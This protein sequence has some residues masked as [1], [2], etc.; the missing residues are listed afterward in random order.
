[1]DPLIPCSQLVGI[2]CLFVFD[3]FKALILTVYCIHVLKS[4]F[5]HAIDL[6]HSDPAKLQETAEG[7]Q[8]LSTNGLKKRQMETKVRNIE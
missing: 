3:K 1:M 7:V 6:G 8:R 2:L 4:I 5:F